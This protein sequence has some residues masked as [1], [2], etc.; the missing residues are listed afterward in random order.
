MTKTVIK[1][2]VTKKGYLAPLESFKIMLLL[3]S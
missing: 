3:K 2:S 1:V